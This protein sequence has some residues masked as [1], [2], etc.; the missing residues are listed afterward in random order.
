MFFRRSAIRRIG[1][2]AAAISS[3]GGLS[4]GAVSPAAASG[5]VAAGFA[6][7][8]GNEPIGSLIGM[9][10]NAAYNSANPIG[11]PAS[12]F[13]VKAGYYQV[14]FPGLVTA[15]TAMKAVGVHVRAINDA[16]CV[17]EH[18]VTKGYANGLSYVAVP[19]VCFDSNGHY[20]DN[21][22]TITYTGGA[23]DTAG[24]VVSALT[25]DDFATS[26]G[27]R[28]AQYQQSS[29]SG[30]VT[31]NRSG[32]GAYSFDLP[33]L[34]NAGVET[35]AITALASGSPWYGTQLRDV[36][37]GV[38]KKTI[39]KTSLG[40]ARRVDVSCTDAVTGQPADTKVSVT[41]ARGVNILGRANLGE[42]YMSAP[43]MTNT[44]W[45]ALTKD[46]AY[47]KIYGLENLTVT[48]N[49]NAPGVYVVNLP[50]Q[51]LGITRPS[52]MATADGSAARCSVMGSYST[53]NM[54]EQVTLFC[55][56]PS[57]SYVDTGFNLQFLTKQ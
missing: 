36:T 55:K 5:Q 38:T 37:C 9:S 30:S 13:H 14:R 15:T 49:R 43:K 21:P 32:T 51:A 48:V 34:S 44:G 53:S 7:I 45:T 47:N 25:N 23:S 2:A 6:V 40:Q 26:S 56:N 4:L 29:V 8:D 20:A 33:Y 57:G 19:V 52:V 50:K 11:P 16:N 41:Y 3:L 54:T 17:P 42:A 22:F 27:Q 39:A 31:Y 46:Q 18:T 12:V 24:E 10:A 35:F 28:T 1:V